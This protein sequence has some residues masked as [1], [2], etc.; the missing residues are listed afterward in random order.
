MELPLVAGAGARAGEGLG[1]EVMGIVLLL[2]GFNLLGLVQGLGMGLA[3]G[4]RSLELGLV[5]WPLVM[6]LGLGVGLT[7]GLAQWSLV[8]GLGLGVGLTLELKPFFDLH[9]GLGPGLTPGVG[10]LELRPSSVGLGVGPSLDLPVGLLVGLG[11]F[12]DFDLMG[13]MSG[14][15]LQ[16]MLLPDFDFDKALFCPLSGVES[17]FGKGLLFF[18]C[19]SGFLTMGSGFLGCCVGLPPPTPGVLSA[20]IGGVSRP[21]GLHS[22][23]VL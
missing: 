4:L 17:E 12:S 10:P 18:F 22:S 16:L 6:G 1:P 2:P 3:L 14:E 9:V 11:A 20:S 8:A 5:Q 21:E 7:L 15:G 13:G 23:A 19:T